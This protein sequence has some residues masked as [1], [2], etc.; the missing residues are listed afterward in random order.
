MGFSRVP[1]SRNPVLCDP[2]FW[3]GCLYAGDWPGRWK[4]LTSRDGDGMANV[5]GR[6]I[7]NPCK[8]A[9]LFPLLTFLRWVGQPRLT[10]HKGCIIC[11]PYNSLLPKPDFYAHSF[12]GFRYLIWLTQQVFERKHYSPERSHGKVSD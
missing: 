11:T 3:V 10:L 4:C 5:P 12:E 7:L 1:S 9:Y 8:T 2:D 6:S